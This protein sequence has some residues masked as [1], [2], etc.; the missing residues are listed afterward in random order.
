MNEHF[1]FLEELRESG[2]TNM[3][4]ALPYLMEEFPELTRQQANDIL[5]NWMKSKWRSVET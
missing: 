2:V 3:F 5:S 1:E 4:G